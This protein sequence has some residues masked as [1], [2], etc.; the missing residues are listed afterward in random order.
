MYVMPDYSF[1]WKEL[2]GLA[3]KIEVPELKAERPVLIHDVRI[4]FAEDKPIPP[5]GW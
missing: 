3:E 4:A 2:F 5:P 1:N